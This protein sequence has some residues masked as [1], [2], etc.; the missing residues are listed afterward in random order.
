MEF[1]AIVQNL[2][3]D[4]ERL[5]FALFGIAIL[6][7]SIVSCIVALRAAAAAK[8]TY[9]E[10]T[11]IS[12]DARRLIGELQTAA[13]ENEARATH[14]MALDGTDNT[15]DAV[16]LENAKTAATVPTALLGR[17]LRRRS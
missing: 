8:A 5:A 16:T 11:V 9:R 3:A 12:A 6:I 10:V 2:G 7:G 15:R 17:A 13:Q 4:P 1:E 14:S